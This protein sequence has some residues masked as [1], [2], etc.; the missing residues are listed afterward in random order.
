M[1]EHLSSL[2]IAPLVTGTWIILLAMLLGNAARLSRR[3][4]CRVRV[5]PRRSR[6]SA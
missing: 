2:P 5:R 6:D 3:Q 4:T 1:I